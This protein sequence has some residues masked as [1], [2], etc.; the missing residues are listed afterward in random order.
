MH[1]LGCA[2][3]RIHRAG[4]DTQGAADADGLIDHGHHLG[5]DD[6]DLGVQ[7]FG[8]TAKQI[9]QGDDG[10]LTAWRA[11]VDIGFPVGNGRCVWPATGVGALAALCLGEQGI[12]LIDQRIAFDLKADGAVTQNQAEHD[13]KYAQGEY[14]N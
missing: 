14:S 11:L 5:F 1:L 2:E 6:A 9:R 4:L 7:L 13:P 10:G 8:V 3:D 12:D